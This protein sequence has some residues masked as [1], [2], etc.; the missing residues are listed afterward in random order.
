MA[1]GNVYALCGC[2]DQATGRRLGTRCPRRGDTGHGSWY[3]TVPLPPGP[4]GQRHRLRRGGFPDYASARAAL[5]RIAVPGREGPGA[6]IVTTGQWLRY[7]LASRVTPRYS[8]IRG[9]TSHVRLYLEPCLGTI[10]LARLRTADVQA[11][12]TTIT[13]TST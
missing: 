5:A 6:A 10:P 11:M 7:W 12:L 3:V 8:T 13:R 1:A 9:Y 4:A 2:R